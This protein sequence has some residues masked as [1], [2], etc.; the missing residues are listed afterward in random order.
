TLALA[1][2]PAVPALGWATT[3]PTASVSTLVAGL[4]AA[5]IAVTLDR[6]RRVR[7]AHAGLVAGFAITLAGVA[8]SAAGGGRGVA[9]F[10]VACVAGV[11][12]AAGAVGL[13][14]FVIE[15]AVVESVGAAGLVCGLAIAAASPVWLAASLTA[16]AVMLTLGAL[17]SDRS[18]YPPVAL[19]AALAA[20]WSWLGS[21]HVTLVEAY[22]LP[23]AAAALALGIVT[24]TTRPASSW[25]TV[26]AAI[27]L[28]LGPT[29]AL[30]IA[31]DDTTRIVVAA[32]A[33]FLVL[34]A[35]A[36]G[37]LQAPL[38][39]GAATLVALALDLVA[40]EAARL[41]RWTVLAAAGALLLWA[42]ATFE[43]RRE[44]LRRATRTLLGFH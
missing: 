37:R 42:G 36:R 24:R 2:I 32:I 38:V 16:T 34:L 33:A 21:A 27:V 9:G 8:T 3:T 26:A 6:A 10:A 40:P 4:V 18:L 12:I 17:R 1:S 7:A 5:A 28:G 43:R 25:T 39:L 11:A 20:T 22:T 35:G 19:A 44:D 30:G 13:R 41:P 15:G 29:A 23:A 14:R 31:H